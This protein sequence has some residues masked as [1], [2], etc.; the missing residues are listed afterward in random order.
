MDHSGL[1]DLYRAM[2]TARAVDRVELE[3]TGRG[4]AFFHVSGAG[5]EASAALAPHLHAGDW[6]H[7]HYRDKALM[8]A[9]GI[10]PK[11]FFDALLCKDES[12]SRGRQMSAHMC[13]PR[14]NV[15]SI[16]G[17][18][19]N[20]ALQA[21]GVAAAV[22]HREHEPLVLC[23]IGDGTTQEG[24]FLEACAE[25]VRS[26]LPV[27]FLVEDNRFS[28]STTTRGKTFYSLP[29]RESPPAEFHGI[30]IHK[31]D[32]RHVLPV[33]E[34][35]GEIVA[36]IRR[37]R[38]PQIVILEVERLTNHTNAD[39]QTIYRDE[40][41]IRRCAEGGDPIANLERHLLD[42]GVSPDLLDTIRREVEH[43]VR[44]QEELAATGPEP[45]P[46]QSAKAML[47]VELTHPS[48][49]VRGDKHAATYTMREAIRATLRHH[50]RTNPL[51]TL[52][53]EDIEDPKGDVFGCTKGLSTEFGG[54]VRNSPLSEST[55]LGASIGRALAGELPVAFLQFADFIPLAFN[56]IVSE[57]GSMYWRTDGQYLTPVIVMAA[58]GA[59]RPGLGPFHA[60]TFESLIAHTPG[61]DV[62][63]PCTAAD[64]AG[65]LNAAFRSGR[66]TLFFYPKSCLN[67]RETM[68]SPDVERQFVPIGPL[69]RVRVGRDLTF[70]AW[71]NTVRLC[72][73]AADALERN[74]GV[75]PEILDLRSLSPWDEQAVLTS[76]AKTAR[77]IVV[78]EDNHTCGFGAE[79]LATVAEKTRVPVA[80]RR[81]TRADTFV[82][83]NFGNQI[84]VLPSYKKVLETAA[85]LLDLNLS[86]IA[87]A[88]VAE[89]IAFVEAIGSGPSDETVIVAELCVK[90]GDLV[91]RGQRVASLE[92]SKSDFE[93]YS[94]VTGTV[95][96]ILVHAGDTVA[97]GAPLIRLRT[98]LDNRR[99]KP[100]TQERSGTAVLSRRP[101][102]RLRMP[103][104]SRELRHFDVGVSAIAAVE[105]SRLITNDELLVPHDGKPSLMTSA[106]VFRRTG[107]ETRCWVDEGEN[108]V[109][110]AVK[111]CWNLLDREALLPSDL[112]LVICSTTSPTAVTPS[113]ACQ[114]LNGL[115]GGKADTMIQAYDINAACSG[116]L[117][118]M[119]AAYDYLQSTPHG[120]VL[121][122]TAEV[123]SPLLDPAD[124][125]TAI[126]FGDAASATLVCGEDHFSRT[127]WRLYRPELS[128]RGDD[129]GS[130]SVPLLN[131]GYIQMDGRKVFTEAVRSMVTSLTRVCQR[132]GIQLGDLKLVVPHQ[133]NQ[134]IID[135][136]AH[137]IGVSVYSN[138]RRHGNTSSTSIPLCLSEIFPTAINGDRLGLCAFGGG[139][140]FGASILQATSAIAA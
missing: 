40:A 43:Q 35:L 113:M 94:S 67:E 116:Y 19:G 52:F 80:M 97:V 110:M 139:F 4:E 18:V 66:P 7:C 13:D 134:R 31:L 86:W 128:A 1:V 83:C 50:L 96:E 74:A 54:R 89:G 36:T 44:H 57:L 14:L 90:P 8:I 39:D 75:E 11:A 125:D 71:G 102:D 122:V 101:T 34:R 3:L 104:H 6:L 137:R 46:A 140:T 28:I 91:Q 106:D 109:N 32:G 61:I 51:V 115:A 53:G 24:E 23:S 105:G 41:E 2:V 81:V 95:E 111:A 87:P 30:P 47:S 25:A 72:E 10:T 55:I 26:Q 17:P 123:L 131:D 15:L 12:H 77:L 85:E 136:I 126:L 65:L 133:A 79:I 64:A 100:T 88:K 84:E 68:T 29:N 98:E 56:Q 107:I 129:D 121:I 37:E 114:V 130:L 112:D 63:M 22:K 135:A 59:Y 42:H 5:H 132:Q 73:Q 99:V 48:H 120:R 92:A 62:F 119:Q 9:R 16:V 93:I 76:T 118:A 27:L 103:S 21:V 49:E 82:P 60:Q 58:C 127:R 78:H 38:G 117:Y 69:R 33:Y 124:F 45:A 20:S 108:A 138:I 70:V